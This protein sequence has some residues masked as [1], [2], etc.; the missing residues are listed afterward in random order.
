MTKTR[1]SAVP[2]LLLGTLLCAL[3]NLSL[4]AV[5]AGCPQKGKTQP[6][7]L[8]CDDFETSSDMMNKHYFEFDDDGGDFRRVDYQSHSGKYALAARFQAGEVSAGHFMY[9][10]GRNPIGSQGYRSRNF[11]EIYWRFYVKLQAGFQGHP[12]KLTRAIS[13]AGPNREQ[14]M[15][16][17][18]WASS[19][20]R[21]TL[22]LDPASGID[23][24]SKLR[25]TTFNDFANLKWIG[26]KQGTTSLQPGRW[27]CIEA[28]VKLN[29]PGKSDGRF[30]FW[31]DD[32]PE[33]L[34]TNLDWV[35]NW[36]KYG[37]NSIFFSN[38]WN[39][40]SPKEQERYLDDL[41]IA[42]KKIGCM[43]HESQQ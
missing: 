19:R 4:F 23:K 26:V 15:I 16:A 27:Y 12:D 37:I 8:W 17:H 30:E 28:H 41:V 33:A 24:N 18:L 31:I 7:V 38:Y 13:Y 6:G 21:S 43:P 20:N 14:A 35:N 32:K 5:E 1:K 9:N 22:L 40:G 39:K 25:T 42:T 11:R 3:I 34:R 29:Q 36:D 10:F 2:A